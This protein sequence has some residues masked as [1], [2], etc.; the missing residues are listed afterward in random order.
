MDVYSIE[1]V[2]RII[3]EDNLT[4]DILHSIL[5]STTRRIEIYNDEESVEILRYIYDSA[6]LNEDVKLEIFQYLEGLK[7]EGSDND[8]YYEE[9]GKFY[10]IFIVTGFLLIIIGI[11]FISFK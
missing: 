7:E 1:E 8:G 9:N 5:E 11:I 2:K 3:E 6:K 4:A 10:K